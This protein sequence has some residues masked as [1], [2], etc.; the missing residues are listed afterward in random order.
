MGWE[1]GHLHFVLQPSWND[2]QPD[3]ERP[4]PF[5]QVDL[6]KAR[7]EPAREEVEAFAA[8]A[9]EVIGELALS[10]EGFHNHGQLILE[11]LSV[12]CGCLGSIRS[13]LKPGAA[14]IRVGQLPSSHPTSWRSEK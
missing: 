4:G 9:R 1:P 12:R 10:A 2:F 7:V 6:F 3:H 5:L 8:I 14:L 11:A 13:T